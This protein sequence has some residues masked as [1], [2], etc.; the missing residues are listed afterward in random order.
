MPRLTVQQMNDL[1]KEKEAQAIID[2]KNMD[3]LAKQTVDNT[4]V[5]PVVQKKLAEDKKKVPT[6]REVKFTKNI[7][8][9]EKYLNGKYEEVVKIVQSAEKEYQD[10]LNELYDSSTSVR[11]D[12]VMCLVYDKTKITAG[13]NKVQKITD[14]LEKQLI[15][16]DIQ[17]E[18]FQKALDMSEETLLS[19]DKLL[20]SNGQWH[21][22]KRIEVTGAGN[23]N[24]FIDGYV[25]NM[26]GVLY[27]ES[28]RI[29]E[30]ITLNY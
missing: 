5:P 29:L 9:F 4:K 13:K 11:S 17:N 23:I 26:Q 14:R 30:N 19:N 25:S 10:T 20:A 22:G 7:T 27:N 1:E 28:R 2:Q 24:S 12:G 8:D 6:P 21:K 15:G 16:S 18:I 3:A